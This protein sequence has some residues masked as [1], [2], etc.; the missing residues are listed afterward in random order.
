M[1][2]GSLAAVA[3]ECF[4]YFGAAVV[5]ALVGAA[6]L[7]WALRAPEETAVY[8]VGRFECSKQFGDLPTKH[9]KLVAC[10]DALRGAAK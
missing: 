4:A 1:R 6:F 5:G 10:R 3:A 7:T 2:A 9:G 8:R